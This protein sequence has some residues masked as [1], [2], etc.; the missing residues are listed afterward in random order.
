[1]NDEHM[2]EGTAQLREEPVELTSQSTD[3]R[4]HIA[5]ED[6]DWS[7]GDWY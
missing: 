3:W 4:N 7:S 5:W 1:M 2:P 6:M